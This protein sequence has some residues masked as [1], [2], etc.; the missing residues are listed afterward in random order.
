[1]G[2]FLLDYYKVN[3]TFIEYG[4]KHRDYSFRYVFFI[5]W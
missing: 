2:A 3:I 1:M 4:G 5:F